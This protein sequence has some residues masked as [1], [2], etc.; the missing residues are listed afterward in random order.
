MEKSIPKQVD[1][2][3]RHSVFL[4][5]KGQSPAEQPKITFFEVTNYQRLTMN[6]GSHGTTLGFL[7]VRY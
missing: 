6:I 2:E 5:F 1:G 4:M 3:F 7:I